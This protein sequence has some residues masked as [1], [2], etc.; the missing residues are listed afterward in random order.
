M[1]KNI[2]KIIVIIITLSTTALYAGVTG[3]IIGRVIDVDTREPL[4]GVNVVVEGTEL[5]AAT[6]ADGKYL[7]TNVPA[8]RYNI[9]ASYIGYQ[10]QTVKN[11]IVIPDQTVTVDFKLKSTVIEID[12]PVIIEAQKEVV[13]RTAVATTRTASAEDFNRLPVQ[14]LTQLVGLQA[15]VRQDETRGWTH[16]RG[17]RFDDVSYLIDGVAARDAIYGVLWSS[18]KPTTEAI[19]EVIVITGSFDP[20]YGEAM[21]GIVQAVTK[22]GGTKTSTRV[23]YT[24]DEIFPKPDLNFGYNQVTWTLGGPIPFYNRLRYFLSTQYF[25]T[26]D[27]RECLYKVKAPRGE[28]AGDAKLTFNVPKSFPLT[29]EGLKLTLDGHHSTYQWHAYSHAWKYFL[30]GVFA[31]RVRSY[32]ANFHLNHMVTPKIVWTLKTGI[33]NTALVRDPR[34]FDRERAD[35]LGFWGFLRKTG[36]WDRYIFMGE[37][38]VLRNPEGLST[39]DALLTLYR[40]PGVKYYEGSDL[41]AARL[42][43]YGV[44]EVFYT[45][46][47]PSYFHYRTTQTKYI[48]GDITWTPNKVHEFKTGIDLTQYTLAE[49]TNQMPNDPNP[50][51]EHFKVHPLTFAAFIQDRADFEDLVIRGGFRF[52]YLDAK[53]KRRLYP[54]SIGGRTEIRDS[55]VP[56]EPKYRISPRLGISFPITERIKFRFSYG[57]FFKNPTFGDLYSCVEFSATDIQKRP[58]TIVGNPDME[59]EKT[60]AYEMGFDAQLSDI[61]AFDLTTYYKDVYDLSGT[62]TVRSIPAYSMYYNVEYARIMGAEFTFTKQL[63]NYWR[64]SASYT[65]QIAKGT[66]STATAEYSRGY[67]LQIDYPL[68]HDMRHQANLDFGLSFPSDFFIIPLR[69]FDGSFIVQYNSGLPYTPTDARGNRLADENSARKPSTFRIDSRLSKSFRVGNL[70]LNLFCDIYNLL[71]AEL[72]QEVFTM[73]GSPYDRGIR[74]VPG[75]F[76]SGLRVG[77]SYY[78]PARDFNHDGY[79]TQMEMYRSFMDAYNDRYT[80]PTYFGMSRRIRVGISLGI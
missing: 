32:K 49:Y 33:F 18:P 59:A 16:I 56:V 23:K 26:D 13:I 25:K 75:Q 52:D 58:N 22:E 55:L 74:Y 65:Y 37:D 3:R 4:V 43:P 10:P 71:N 15:G 72:V 70:Q 6:D 24:T 34:N 61:F 42:N 36:I 68:D 54:E 80:I 39:K 17:G 38:W 21:S 46:A 51:W 73:T 35:T 7:I 79:I 27:Y 20:E 9:T 76:S 1:S 41:R 53:V 57:H 48:K 62:R 69:D 12:K 63:S 31:N 2:T 77:D 30:Q 5:G 78:H 11:V 29:K 14:T 60:V 45:G 28:Y 8:G 50:F 47:D 19:Q 64:A 67:P 66:A 40:A 44:Y